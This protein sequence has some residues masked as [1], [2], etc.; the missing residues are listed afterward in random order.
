MPDGSE[1]M[2]LALD[3]RLGAFSAGWKP[4][5]PATDFQFTVIELR[6]GGKT[7]GEGKTSL[8]SKVIIDNEIKSIAL[9]NYAQAPVILRNVKK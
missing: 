1:R 4:T 9:E 3:R 2:I 6:L 7:P 5:A 8:T